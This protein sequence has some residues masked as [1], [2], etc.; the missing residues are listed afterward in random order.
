[1]FGYGK[2]VYL[3]AANEVGAAFGADDVIVKVT[4]YTGTADHS[5]FV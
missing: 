3:I 5:D 1:L 2:D 4:G